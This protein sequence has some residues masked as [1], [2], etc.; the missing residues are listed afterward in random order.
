MASARK[1]RE[2]RC[3]E[4]C[5]DYEATR[6]DWE[7]LSNKQVKHRA[8]MQ[9]NRHKRHPFS[10]ELGR[11]VLCESAPCYCV[12]HDASEASSHQKTCPRQVR[13]EKSPSKLAER[14]KGPRLCSR[15]PDDF[16]SEE[17]STVGPTSS[18]RA[19]DAVQFYSQTRFPAALL[20]AEVDQR[21]EQAVID[22][23]APKKRTKGANARW[24]ALHDILV[25]EEALAASQE[26]DS[27]T[28]RQQE[29]LQ[30]IQE[31][32]EHFITLGKR[33]KE[34][35][36]RDQA[37]KK[38][39]L[40]QNQAKGDQVVEETHKVIRSFFEEQGLL[41]EPLISH[42]PGYLSATIPNDEGFSDQGS[43]L[44]EGNGLA[45]FPN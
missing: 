45:R 25:E 38:R 27:V 10:W 40:E 34:S 35:H 20:D 33:S 39:K 41:V 16:L 30:D 22:L 29:I 13:Q 43:F 17:P 44:E 15:A 14:L 1:P 36:R 7:T 28:A 3:R 18:L 24:L 21:L 11:K 8:E 26:E 32:Q 42:V 31:L 37:H 23:P 6:L 19:A 5:E 12:F 9:R 4:C 2:V